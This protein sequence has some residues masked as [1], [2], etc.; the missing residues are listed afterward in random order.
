MEFDSEI[1]SIIS[2][3]NTRAIQIRSK[4]N[5]GIGQQKRLEDDDDPL[6][7]VAFSISEDDDSEQ[8]NQD[9]NGEAEVSQQPSELDQTI[10]IGEIDDEC[11]K[12][13]EL[14]DSKEP[15]S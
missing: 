8:R 11:I 10:V 5:I 1:M 3:I 9:I 2:S 7:N 12:L 6:K 4:I 13:D 14:K 15:K